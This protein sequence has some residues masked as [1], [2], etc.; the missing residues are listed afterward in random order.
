MPPQNTHNSPTLADAAG[1]AALQRAWQKVQRNGG[2]PGG[3]GITPA[4][5]ARQAHA[6]LSSLSQ[7]LLA[8]TYRPGPAR[9]RRV[10]K[11]NG[12]HR[13]LAIPCVIDRIAQTAVLGL[14]APALD[15][16]MTDNSYAYRPGRSAGQAIAHAEALIADGHAWIVDA[17]ISQFFDSVPHAR[18]VHDLAI[19]I[20]DPGLYAL[21][22]RWVQSGGRNGSGLPQGAPLSPLLANLYLHPLDRV[23]AREGIAA[24]RYADDFVLLARTRPE[25]ERAQA[26]AARALAA[27]GLAL[28]A[29]KTR[30]VPARKGTLFLG[31]RLRAAGWWRRLLRRLI[32]RART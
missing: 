25:A 7:A 2:G 28:H 14:L 13:T 22:V 9:L 24:V 31:K 20:D 16:R 21:L 30:I 19:W 17:D 6:R 3:D 26:R 18:L 4:R 1:H 12:G 23:L 5:F 29:G 11:P 27:R 8:G 32:S 15:R 10:K